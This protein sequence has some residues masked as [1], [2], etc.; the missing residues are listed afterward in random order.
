MQIR[1][2]DH[3]CTSVIIEVH[4][5]TGFAGALFNEV[6]CRA[7]TSLNR[8]ANR[9]THSFS[10]GFLCLCSVYPEMDGFTH[11]GDNICR[12]SSG[13]LFM[14]IATGNLRFLERE[15]SSIVMSETGYFT[16]GAMLLCVKISCVLI[17]DVIISNCKRHNKLNLK[18]CLST[19]ILAYASGHR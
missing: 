10:S 15:D 9:P 18:H 12:D 8:S 17:G 1:R 16:Q 14:C 19:F 4:I 6:G 13:T 3:V 7:C 5:V 2:D 11:I